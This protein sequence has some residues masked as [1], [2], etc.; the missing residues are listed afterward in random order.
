MNENKETADKKV[1]KESNAIQNFL[2]YQI[3]MVAVL[4]IAHVTKWGPIG[5]YQQTHVHSSS[6]L[7]LFKL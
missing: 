2:F 4:V 5:K 3:N 6:V 7:I 1:L